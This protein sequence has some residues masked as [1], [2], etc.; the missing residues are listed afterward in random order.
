LNRLGGQIIYTFACAR[1]FDPDKQ[2]SEALF[3]Y[4]HGAL[5]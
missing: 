5:M 1:A 4:P 3:Q 2:G